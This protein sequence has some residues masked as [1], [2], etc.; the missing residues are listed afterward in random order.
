[1]SPPY[2]QLFDYYSYLVFT[3]SLLYSLTNFYFHL[4]YAFAPYTIFSCTTCVATLGH[5]A[6]YPV[7]SFLHFFSLAIFRLLSLLLISIVWH[8]SFLSVSHYSLLQILM[9]AFHYWSSH[10]VLYLPQFVVFHFFQ[11]SILSTI[12]KLFSPY[13][14]YWFLNPIVSFAAASS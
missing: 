10:N 3:C 9:F 4:M 7:S 1:M 14:L 12:P 6:F 11:S 5:I 2:I 8:F 13:I